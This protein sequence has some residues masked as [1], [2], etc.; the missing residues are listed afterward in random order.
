[1]G[2]STA[3]LQ[4]RFISNRNRVSRAGLGRRNTKKVNLSPI[5][6]KLGN[7]IVH[8]LRL[9]Q[10][11]PASLGHPARMSARAEVISSSYTTTLIPRNVILRVAI[12]PR[13]QVGARRYPVPAARREESSLLGRSFM[14]YVSPPS[15]GIYYNMTRPRSIGAF[16]GNVLY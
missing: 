5:S 2:D 13:L 15:D 9:T 10:G 7:V 16:H 1:M 14:L 8:R 12:P 6:I 3:G 4:S 11:K